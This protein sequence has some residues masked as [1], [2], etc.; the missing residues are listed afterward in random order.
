MWEKCWVDPARADLML[1]YDGFGFGEMR[2]TNQTQGNPLN[3]GT[4]QRR[5]G[6][7]L[8][9][10]YDNRSLV[11]ANVTKAAINEQ[12]PA[13]T[14]SLAVAAG[15][16]VFDELSSERCLATAD[17]GKADVV[18]F[19]SPASLGQSRKPWSIARFPDRTTVSQ[20]RLRLHLGAVSD[21][22]HRPR[23]GLRERWHRARRAGGTGSPRPKGRRSLKQ[24]LA[25]NT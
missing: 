17:G 22:D 15:T 21:P 7:P 24:I 19:E 8:N 23:G 25:S 1:A 6:C 10:T 9:W 11:E 13:D 20:G 2:V 18:K 5:D 12:L 3:T 14:F 16:L 4:T